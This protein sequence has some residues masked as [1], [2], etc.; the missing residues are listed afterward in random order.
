[1]FGPSGKASP[2]RLRGAGKHVAFDF[3]ADG[4]LLIAASDWD[5]HVDTRQGIEI[6]VSSLRSS[7]YCR[8]R[9]QL[10][11]QRTLADKVRASAQPEAWAPWTTPGE[12]IEAVRALPDGDHALIELFVQEGS[13]AKNVIRLVRL[14]RRERG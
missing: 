12:V 9:D 1:M 6:S 8:T 13:R 4:R 7:L 10:S 5:P 3:T 14:D 11:G 2:S